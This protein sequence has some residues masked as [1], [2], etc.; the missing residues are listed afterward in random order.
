MKAD[1]A[2]AENKYYV[3]DALV[4]WTDIATGVSEIT[5]AGKEVSKTYINAQG[6]KSDKPFDGLNI[7]ITR[8]SDG[9][10]QTTKVVR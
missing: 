9:S 6:I 2:N 3:V 1:R 5:T 10:T 7:V 8:Y 4:P